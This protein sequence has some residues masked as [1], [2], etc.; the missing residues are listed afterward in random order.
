[1]A[2]KTIFNPLLEEGF[3]KIT[4]NHTQTITTTNGTATAFLNPKTIS[5]NSVQSFITRVTAIQATTG[6]VSVWEYKGA[7]KNL[8]GVTTMVDTIV[9]EQLAIDPL[10]TT[11]TTN[12]TSVGGQLRL[13]A[14]GQ[15]GK[16]IKW[17]AETIFHELT[18]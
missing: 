11:W 2:T 10:A 3:Q 16:T 13:E 18:F 8:A 4:V 15:V 5:N 1:M 9:A 6:H 7:I 12:F 14:V 17:Y